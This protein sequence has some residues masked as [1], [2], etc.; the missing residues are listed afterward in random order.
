MNQKSWVRNP[1]GATNQIESQQLTFAFLAGG[2]RFESYTR[3]ISL[4]QSV[5]R[6]FP[7]S[8]VSAH[9]PERSKGRHLRCRASC[10]VGSNPAVCMYFMYFMESQPFSFL[11]I[12]KNQTP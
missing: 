7:N 9:V 10:F 6:C 12:K 4:A 8:I 2:R 5:E 1:L 11:L 3:V